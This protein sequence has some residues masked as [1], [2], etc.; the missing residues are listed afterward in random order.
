MHGNYVLLANGGV[1]P[2]LAGAFRAAVVTVAVVVVAGAMSAEERKCG[3]FVV[4]SRLLA[5]ITIVVVGS[6]VEVQ[7]ATLGKGQTQAQFKLHTMCYN[8]LA[9]WSSGWSL[10]KAKN[11]VEFNCL[12]PGLADFTYIY[13]FVLGGREGGSEGEEGLGHGDRD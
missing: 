5:V 12:R 10:D 11:K 9:K 8:Q 7:Q 6:I 13:R 3:K 4:V 2:S 1:G